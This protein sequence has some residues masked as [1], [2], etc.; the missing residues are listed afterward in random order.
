MNGRFEVTQADYNGNLSTVL[1][2]TP[3]SGTGENTEGFYNFQA[4]NGKVN[5]E[6]N[7]TMNLQIFGQNIPL[8]IEVLG[9]GDITYVSETRFTIDD[10]RYGLMTY[11]VNDRTNN[12]LVASTRYQT[13]TLSATIDLTLDIYLSKQ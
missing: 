6:V 12:S 13:D 10:P 2:Q 5:Y 7:S 1:G 8:P 4:A 11:D 9:T 3:L